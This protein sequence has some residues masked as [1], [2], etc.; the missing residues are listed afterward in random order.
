[1]VAIHF[2][3]PWYD[4]S[5]LTGRKTSIYLSIRCKKG[6]GVTGIWIDLWDFVIGFGFVGWVGSVYNICF[7]EFLLYLRDPPPPVFTIQWVGLSG[8]FLIVLKYTQYKM[9]YSLE[10]FNMG[11]ALLGDVVLQLEWI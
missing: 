8:V 9:R 6:A 3:S 7:V 1:M 10:L 2:V 4:P 5:R 11:D